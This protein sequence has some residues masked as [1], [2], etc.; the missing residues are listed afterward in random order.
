M[1]KAHATKSFFAQV[2]KI[3]RQHQAADSCD[4][5]M[6]TSPGWS[7]AVV[8]SSK[9]VKRSRACLRYIQRGGTLRDGERG[10]LYS[11]PEDSA[12]LS[13]PTA[14]TRDFMQQVEDGLGTKLDWVAVMVRIVELIPR[15]RD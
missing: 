15:D 7:H 1:S 10:R 12:E 3:I 5:F 11:A 6:P 13:E 2:K 4:F 9:G 8:A 14:Y